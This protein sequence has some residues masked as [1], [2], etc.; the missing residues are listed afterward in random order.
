MNRILT[1]IVTY[2]AI[3]WA[4]RC[5]DS[6]YNSTIKTDVIVIDNGSTDDTQIYIKNNYPN[7]IFVQSDCNLGFGRANNIGIK[8][9]IEEGYDYVYLLNQDAWLYRDTFEKMINAHEKHKEYGILSPLQIEANEKHLDKNFM[10]N[11]CHNGKNV[12]DNLILSKEILISD[13]D[14]V[15]AAHWLISKECILKVGLFSPAFPHYCEDDNYADRA[16][17]HGYKVG[18]V[19]NAYAIHDREFRTIDKKRRIYDTYINSIMFVSF[20]KRVIKHPILSSYFHLLTAVVK[21]KSFLPFIYLF[22]FT[23][24]LPSILRYREMSKEEGAF[25]SKI[26]K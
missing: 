18:V 2:N 24:D 1:V 11:L 21:Y 15:M 16:I 26:G 19:T 5:L 13:I 14:M 3:Q 12:I 17:Y 6:L 25:Y 4:K 7:V 20:I 9:A 10:I 8:K 22:R 23:R